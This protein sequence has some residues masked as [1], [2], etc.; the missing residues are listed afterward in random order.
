MKKPTTTEYGIT[1]DDVA[2]A[3][4]IKNRLIIA[5]IGLMILGVVLLTEYDKT[6]RTSGCY[7]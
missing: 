1:E 7:S 3:E 6:H 2:K 5:A 4:S